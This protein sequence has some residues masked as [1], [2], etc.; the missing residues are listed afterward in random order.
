MQRDL[1]A[2][3]QKGDRASFSV[4]ADASMARLYNLAQLMLSDGDLAED[5]GPGDAH[6]RLAGSASVARS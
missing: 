1:V 4:V 6:R 2:P 5:A 3:A